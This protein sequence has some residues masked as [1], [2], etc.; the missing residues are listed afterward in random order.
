[1]LVMVV[2]KLQIVLCN[3]TSELSDVA[4]EESYNTNSIAK[5]RAS[6]RGYGVSSNPSPELEYNWDPNDP[7]SNVW[8]VFYGSIC[9]QL[10]VN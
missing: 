7:L 9:M 8:A 5:D 6:S 1:M 4:V 3:N 2:N 10:L